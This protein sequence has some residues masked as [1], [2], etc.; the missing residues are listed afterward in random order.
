MLCCVVLLHSASVAQAEVGD[1]VT[2]QRL[3][4]EGGSAGHDV[5]AQTVLTRKTAL[6]VA[7]EKG[8]VEVVQL[9]LA[10]GADVELQMLGARRDS[11]FQGVI[12]L[13]LRE[14]VAT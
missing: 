12:C 1:V 2:V 6:Y 5:N 7:A 4:Q 13:Q 14:E 8:S 10:A 11:A 9:L 3:L